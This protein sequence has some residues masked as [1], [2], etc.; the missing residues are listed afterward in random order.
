MLVCS[1][2]II[3]AG[4]WVLMLSACGGGG[5]G[6]SAGEGGS[7]SAAV[8]ISGTASYQRIPFSSTLGSGLD[9]N[10]IQVLPIKG[11]DVQALGASGSV[12]ASTTTSDTGTYSLS[13]VGNTNVSIRIIARTVSSSGAVWNVEVR[14]NTNGS[15]LYVLDG[16]LSS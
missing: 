15:A 3:F 13:V 12:L 6:E 16:G 1:G 9:F 8:V 2:K 10:N 4:L 14:D 5:G 7:S 11:V